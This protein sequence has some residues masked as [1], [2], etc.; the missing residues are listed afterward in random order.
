M[1]NYIILG[2]LQ[3]VFEWL[4]VSSEGVV[5]LASQ[6]LNINANPID[7]ALFAHSGTLLAALIYFRK[8]WREVLTFKNKSLLKFL[9]IST[10]IS[11]LIGFIMYNTVRSVAFGA[12]FLL[13]MG[14]GLLATAFFNKSKRKFN[15]NLTQLALFSG[16]LQGFAVIP[17]P[18][19]SGSTIFSLSLGDMKPSQILRISY[20]M[21]VPVV[22]AS[23]VY[24]GLKDFSLALESWPTLVFSFIIGIATLDFLIKI[25]QK[26]NFFKFAL[27]FGIL[28]LFGAALELVFV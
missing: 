22:L 7:F 23:S 27:I 24:V 4:P 28:C 16:L 11:L 26:I 10:T 20:M 18:S 21:S 17:G 25:S 14:F 8:D 3:G 5:A 6:F 19:R 13:L 15:L 2:I 9:I 1:T 12:G